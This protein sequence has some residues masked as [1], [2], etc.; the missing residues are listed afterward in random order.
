MTDDVIP[1]LMSSNALF[2]SS[3]L[4]VFF[5]DI[6]HSNSRRCERMQGEEH[7]DCVMVSR[8]TN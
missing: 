4:Y 1:E 3:W 8:E 6:A 5:H 2:M 7:C